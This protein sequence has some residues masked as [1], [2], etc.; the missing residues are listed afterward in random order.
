MQL[1]LLMVGVVEFCCK[2]VYEGVALLHFLPPIIFLLPFTPIN[3]C[4]LLP[5][6]VETPPAEPTLFDQHGG[7]VQSI[8]IGR[9]KSIVSAAFVGLLHAYY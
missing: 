2:T 1:V 5:M 4:I 7:I 9:P 8:L 3:L 6:C